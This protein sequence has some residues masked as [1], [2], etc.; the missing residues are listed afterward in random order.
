MTLGI[1]S[2]VWWR[3]E[4]SRVYRDAAGNKTSGPVERGY[5]RETTIVGESP[6]MWLLNV[7]GK[8][9]KNGK[10]PE[11]YATSP[12]E[13]ERMIWYRENKHAIGRAVDRLSWGKIDDM[14]PVFEKLRAVAE[15]V[16][17]SPG[18]PK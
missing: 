7:G 15:I 11:G 14:R 9:P 5:W 6:R 3:D 1:G 12:E 8:L 13:L 10:V 16:G 2:T 18:A 4:N 17:Y